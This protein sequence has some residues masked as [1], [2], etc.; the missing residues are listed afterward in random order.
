MADEISKIL[1]DISS[2]ITYISNNLE[3]MAH[4]A[5][6]LKQLLLQTRALLGAV[7]KEKDPLPKGISQSLL[8]LKTLYAKSDFDVIAKDVEKLVA[9][10]LEGCQLMIGKMQE[11]Q[12]CFRNK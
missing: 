4:Y 7:E 2:P 8:Q 9:E 6:S 11:L 10:S 3:T 12:S 5:K 1:H